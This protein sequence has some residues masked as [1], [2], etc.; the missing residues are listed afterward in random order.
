MEYKRYADIKRL[1]YIL[2]SLKKHFPVSAEILD[3]GC[4]NGII[5]RSVGKEG[6]QVYGIDISDKAINKARE[7]TKLSNVKFDVISAEQLVVE[8][9]KYHA[10]I[11]SEVLEHLENPEKLLQVLS[12]SLKENGILIVTVPNGKGPREV[13]VTKP[14]IALQKKNNRLWKFIL[15]LKKGLGYSGTTIQS[16]AGDLTHIQ[17]FTKK[18][19]TNLAEKNHFDIIDFGKTN[20]MDDVFPFSFLTKKVMFLQKLDAAIA[21]ILPSRLTGSFVSVWKKRSLKSTEAGNDMIR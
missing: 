12:Q 18:T 7:L 17:F 16:D 9:K 6:Y 3:V 20:F 10:I 5:A 15:R 19:L 14:T 2:K 13:L 11:C 4:G 1:K 8:G 21:E